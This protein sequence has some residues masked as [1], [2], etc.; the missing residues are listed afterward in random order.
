V[1][2]LETQL[3][4]L[5]WKLLESKKT[6]ALSNAQARPSSDVPVSQKPKDN[7]QSEHNKNLSESPTVTKEQDTISNP[8]PVSQNVAQD[9]IKVVK[10]IETFQDSISNTNEILSL[11]EVSLDSSFSAFLKDPQPI[12]SDKAKLLEARNSQIFKLENKSKDLAKSID[13]LNEFINFHNQFV[14][15]P[16]LPYHQF[17][18]IDDARNALIKSHGRPVSSLNT[19]IAGYLKEYSRNLSIVKSTLN[20]INE[21]GLFKTSVFAFD[22]GAF[23]EQTEATAREIK[24]IDF[25]KMLQRIHEVN[26]LIN[27]DNFTI[28]YESLSVSENADYLG[29]VVQ[30]KQAPTVDIPKGTGSFD[31]KIGFL[32][33]E[34]VKIDLSPTL[35]FE[36][37]V[38]PGEYLFNTEGQPDGFALVSKSNK[39][40]S[41]M[42]VGLL[43]NVYKRSSSNFKVGGSIGFGIG[44]QVAPRFTLGPTLIIGRKERAIFSTGVIVGP[45]ILPAARFNQ[46]TDPVEVSSDLLQSG[47]PLERRGP[48]AGFYVGI[49]FNLFGAKNKEFFDTGLAGFGTK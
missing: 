35:I 21:S 7:V 36:N 19:E 2:R 49:G 29:F 27:K 20:V 44:E 24:G 8:I 25:N 1:L 13:K 41:A 9:S 31:F 42:G 14:T 43:M 23:S 11:K 28:T 10:A 12:E 30:F 22:L 18:K 37:G 45:E 34:G 32:I 39:T 3:N 17:T 16:T 26:A 33:R 38:V 48:R 46:F 5:S 6:T 4:N 40:R 47:V 15:L